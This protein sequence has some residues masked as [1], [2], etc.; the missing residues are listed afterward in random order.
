MPPVDLLRLAAETNDEATIRQILGPLSE[1]E[2]AEVAALAREIVSATVARG[3]DARNLGPMLL[4]AYGVLPATEIRKL[5]WRSNHLPVETAEVLRGRSPDRLGPIVADLLERVGGGR[6]WR[7][8]RQ[9]V[10]DGTIPRPDSPAYTIGML[11]AT[12]W[13]PVADLVAHDPDLLEVE[14]WRLFE[15]EGGGEDSLA[16][17]EKFAGDGWGG[18][19]RSMAAADPATRERLLDESLAALARDFSQYRAGW[20][21]RFH[22]SLQPTDEERAAR[23]EPYLG[24]LRS[25][26]G[27]TVSFAVG[28]LGR[29]ERAGL[30]PPAGLLDRIGPVLSEGS[31]G[32]AKAGLDL[33][34]RSAAR[35]PDDAGRAAMVAAEALRH[36]ASDVQKAALALIGRL[37]TEPDPELAALVA[38]RLPEIAASQRPAAATLVERLGGSAAVEVAAVVPEPSAAAAVRSPLDPSR[39]LEPVTTLEALVDVAV[40]VLETG[41]PADDIERVLE[42]V[43]RLPDVRSE[44]ARRLVAPIAKRARTLLGRRDALPFNGF[45]AQADVAGLLLAWTT[46]E[47]VA[48]ADVHRT[49]DAGAGAFLSAR[50]R[51]ATEELARGRARRSISLPTHRG[52]WIEP[53]KLVERLA[54]GPPASS[55]DLIAAVLRI[56]PE[57]RGAALASAAGLRGE[58]GAVV[59]YALGGKESIGRTA[60][61]WIAAARVRSPGADDAAVDRRHSGFGP[62]AALAARMELRITKPK[63]TYEVLVLDV[64]PPKSGRA[65][66]DVPTVLM[67]ARTTE[68]SWLGRSNPATLRW[69]ATI[70]PGYRETWAAVG[71]LLIGSNVDWWSADW[72]N[73]AYLEPFLEPW[74]EMGPHALTLLGIALGAKE[75][76]ERGLATDIA[77]LALADGRVDATGLARGFGTAAAVALD[78]PQRWATSLADVAAESDLHARVVAEAIGLAL[79]SIVDRRPGSLVPLLRV[80]DELLAAAGTTV[81]PPARAPLDALARSSGLAGRLAK[82]IRGRGSN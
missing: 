27:P 69:I 79:A 52:G 57:G 61:W 36:P 80:L 71:S 28:A 43:R 77:R 33:V 41:E 24:L 58:E 23:V 74:A 51:E 17:H 59:R 54:A 76:G 56:A 20:F 22:E 38:A 44:P 53:G 11:S 73:R 4:L 55:L 66:V 67:L 37:A 72:A 14:A 68:F 26:I 39:A 70:Q 62:Q 31:A 65:G 78:R 50:A 3:V 1:A 35:S 19:F 12:A 8:V 49:V 75:A 5:G 47:V 81:A 64:Q 30:L 34:G 46:G 25:R 13:S 32:T 2:R 16:N 48:S 45:D 9:L 18:E 29:V 42:G 60:A 15:V 6:A 21:S 82:S 10:R 63:G 40:S 7:T